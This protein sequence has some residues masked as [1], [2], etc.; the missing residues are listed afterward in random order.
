M[1]ER[2]PGTHDFIHGANAKPDASSAPAS[3]GI[4]VHTDRAR[5]NAVIGSVLVLNDHTVGAVSGVHG[6]S[7]PSSQGQSAPCVDDRSEDA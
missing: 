7:P 6:C 4:Y 2:Y 5:H 1:L 3:N